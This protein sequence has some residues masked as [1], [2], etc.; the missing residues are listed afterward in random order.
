MKPHSVIRYP[1]SVQQLKRGF[2]TLADLLA[3]TLGPTQGTI[4]SST[5]LKSR[6]E[7][8]IDAGTA[9]RRLTELPDPRQNVGAMLLRGLVWRMHE[10]VGDGGAIT[11]ILAQ[12]LLDQSLR[13]VIA[14]ANPMLVLS[15]LKRG[16]KVALERLDDLS[17]PVESE[18]DLAAVAY[19]VTGEREMSFI[20]GEMFDILGV[21]GNI[22]VEDYMA[23]YLEREYIDGG[24]WEG[25]LISPYLINVPG[26][27]AAIL[28]DIRVALYDG[29]VSSFDEARALL[30]LASQFKPPHLLLVAH[31]ISGEALNLFVGTS[32][33]TDLKL[34]AVSLRRAGEKARDDL[35]DLAI[36]SG[37]LLLSPQLGRSLESIRSEDFGR[38][39][40]AEANTDLLLVTGG[41]GDP[42]QIRQKVEILQRQLRLLLFGDSEQVE[43]QTRLGRLSGNTGILKVGAHTQIER[44]YLH[45][46]G[47]QAIKTLRAALEDGI[48]PGGGV[49]YLECVPDVE[50]LSKTMVEDEASGV[51]AVASALQTP[52][53][54]LLKN[55][56]LQ[57]SGVIQED[58]RCL[59]NGFVY[60]VS[61]R[62]ILGARA[63]GVL[64]SAKVLKLALETA[65]SG[66]AMAL[67]TQTLVLKK[68]PK[69]SYEP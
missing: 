32:M 38:A 9:A 16:V 45:Q 50:T 56:G 57:S 6:P 58:L 2:D 11:A 68:M 30:D 4:L 48:L 63:S 53:R 40:R 22:S 18:E 12:S 8:L 55:A 29:Y 13:F 37:A 49:A 15:G 35:E 60:D 54:V 10:R 19:S 26:K 20:L 25:G 67:S 5:E 59:P 69:V 46:K 51:R 1:E 21:M 27:G 36:L 23:P 39:R 17:F 3:A 44:D 7:M 66:A 52:F 14:G 61:K 33:K 62:E 64:D 28:Q 34:I 41:G 47:Q 24:R 42:A 65:A 43:L 31:K